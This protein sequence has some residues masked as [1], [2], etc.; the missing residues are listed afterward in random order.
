[1]LLNIV[2]P[3]RTVA[4][5]HVGDFPRA[6][7]PNVGDVLE[8]AV[9]GDPREGPRAWALP[10]LGE[11]KGP[12]ETRVACRVTLVVFLFGQRTAAARAFVSEILPEV[13]AVRD[14][15]QLGAALGRE[16]DARADTV[17]GLCG[18]GERAAAA[19]RARIPHGAT[20][21]R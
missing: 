10:N 9:S 2:C 16:A 14:V 15:V 8:L 7:I 18:I 4:D 1:M 11:R 17:D 12:P 5:L 21:A 13:Q 6:E 3:D 20:P 19:V